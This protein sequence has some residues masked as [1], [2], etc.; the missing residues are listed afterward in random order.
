MQNCDTSGACSNGA[1][2]PPAHDVEVT[3]RIMSEDRVEVTTATRY[4]SR[5]EAT[6]VSEH[7]EQGA[8]ITRIAMSF[9]GIKNVTLE[10]QPALEWLRVPL[11]GTERWSLQWSDADDQGSLDVRNH[12][13]EQVR[14]AGGSRDA[15]RMT[16]DLAF[17][18][19]EYFDVQLWVDPATRAVLKTVGTVRARGGALDTTYLYRFTS[20]LRSGPGY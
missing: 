11:G 10:P 20:T 8:A 2:P 7:T 5:W 9:D 16:F 1:E 3:R 13:R 19:D 18:G 12:G 17:G 6:F 14:A 15:V 4:S